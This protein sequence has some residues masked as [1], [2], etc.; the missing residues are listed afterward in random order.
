MKKILKIK[1]FADFVKKK[2]DKVRNH[3]HLTGK[4]RD[5]AHSKG[6][7]NVIQDKRKITPYSIFI[8]SVTI[9]VICSLKI[10]WI[11]RMMQ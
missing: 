8:I 7:K 11:K 10:Y 1:T 3:C 2:S 5:P 4:Y 9:I 6:N